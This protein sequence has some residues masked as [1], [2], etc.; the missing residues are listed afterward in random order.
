MCPGVA[1]GLANIELPLVQ[2]LYHFDWEL[3]GRTRPEDLDMTES[4]V[5]LSEGKKSL[6]LVANSYTPSLNDQI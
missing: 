4:L 2:L 1:F 3:P 5:Q 6:Y